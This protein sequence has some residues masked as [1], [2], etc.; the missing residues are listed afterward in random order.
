MRLD[1]GMQIF[2]GSWGTQAP[3]QVFRRSAPLPGWCPS[4]VGTNQLAMVA[5]TSLGSYTHVVVYTK[6]SLAEQTTPAA[7][8]FS[9]TSATVTDVVFVDQDLSRRR[10]EW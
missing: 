10:G 1:H 7:L 8:N 3:S 5:N 6:S 9:D 4:V 2:N